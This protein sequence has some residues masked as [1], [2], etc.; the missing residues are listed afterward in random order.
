MV[1]LYAESDLVLMSIRTIMRNRKVIKMEKGWTKFNYD[2]GAEVYYKIDNEEETVTFMKDIDGE[3]ESVTVFF[4]EL[5]EVYNK[6][7]NAHSEDYV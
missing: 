5:E 7:S 3:Q 1:A 6:I 2:D 4:D